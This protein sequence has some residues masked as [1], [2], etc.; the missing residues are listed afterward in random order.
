M[1]QWNRFVYVDGHVV[2]H[3]LCIVCLF[4]KYIDYRRNKHAQPDNA[5]FG[6]E[7]VPSM[8]FYGNFPIWLLVLNDPG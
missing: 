5:F 2:C 1:R 6:Y 8:G 3:T 4:L 7:T